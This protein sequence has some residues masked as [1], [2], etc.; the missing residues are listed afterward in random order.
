MRIN[1]FRLKPLEQEIRLLR[2][3]VSRLA[4]LKELELQQVHRLTTRVTSAAP[5][6]LAST[7]VSYADP[8]YADIVDRIERTN[9]RKL[10]DDE[11]ARIAEV[12]ESLKQDGD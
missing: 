7:A 4:D 3:E 10:N 12:L 1:F 11:A 2:A 6:D 5:A 9:G 8:E